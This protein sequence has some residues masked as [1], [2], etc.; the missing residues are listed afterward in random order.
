MAKK[1]ATG[2]SNNPGKST[3]IFVNFLLHPVVIKIKVNGNMRF[4]MICNI[5]IEMSSGK[6]TWRPLCEP[7]SMTPPIINAMKS[8]LVTIEVT[9]LR[10]HKTKRHVN[11]PLNI[12]H[13][14]IKRNLVTPKEAVRIDIAYDTKNQLLPV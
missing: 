13:G 4:G 7:Y 3:S 11:S 6:F 1:V 9:I 14:P 8:P 2:R 12:G 5:N 10:K